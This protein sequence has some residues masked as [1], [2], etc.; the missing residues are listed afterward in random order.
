MSD[1]IDWDKIL[2]E[3]H[4]LWE[5]SQ[6]RKE[7]PWV[8][9]LIKVMAR[10]PKGTL[11]R[12]VIESVWRIREPTNLNMPKAFGETVQSAFNTHNSE[13]VDSEDGLFFAYGPHGSRK[14][15]VHLD[16]IEPWLKKKG[17]RPI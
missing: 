3:A 5:A 14:W 16:K 7:Q 13:K 17:L 12:F 4:K 11:R 15:G 6:L 9:D 2:E 8:L 10:Y 1:D